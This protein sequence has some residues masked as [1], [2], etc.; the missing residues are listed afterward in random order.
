MPDEVFASQE[1]GM[2]PHSESSATSER[3]FLLI[4]RIGRRSLHRY[5]L[6]REDR[7][8]DV[9]L[10]RYDEAAAEPHS[11]GVTCEF[12]PG[13]KV[14]GYHR[15]LQDNAGLWRHYDYVALFDEDLA[16]NPDVIDR[17]FAIGAAAN[18]KIFQPALSH[19]SYF[20]YAA[21][22]RNAC[23]RLRHVN[24][25]EMMCPVFRSDILERVLPLFGL[26]YESGIDLV[27]CN[28]VAETPFDF[29]VIDAAPVRHTEPVGGRKQDNGFG[30]GR[31]YED[32]IAGVLARYGIPWLPCVPYAAV[33]RSGRTIGNRALLATSA[34]AV[35][36][37]IFRRRPWRTRLRS[38]LVHWRHV[39]FR[40][41]RNIPVSLNGGGGANPW[42]VR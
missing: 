12:R 5:W 37:A 4:S 16:A 24:F 38:L 39:T 33:T 29:A 35:L 40:A 13:S 28:A 7:T 22:L 36:P 34:I 9:F 15:L 42:P 18:L 1:F 17:M 26:E 32:D 3:R 23:Y 31:R 8:Y 21:L 14:A 27:W 25:V 6:A 2:L 41:A 10:S 20:S 19:D 30:S 11:S